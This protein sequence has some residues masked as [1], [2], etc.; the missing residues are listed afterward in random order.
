[1]INQYYYD[2]AKIMLVTYVPKGYMR[3]KSALA[4][5]FATGVLI[6]ASNEEADELLER[7]KKERPDLFPKPT[8]RKK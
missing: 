5:Q 4:V 6:Q 8:A 3:P 2:P 1:M 7:V